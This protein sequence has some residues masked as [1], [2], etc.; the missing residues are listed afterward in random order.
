MWY[1]P[2]C[3][4]NTHTLATLTHTHTLTHTYSHETHLHTYICTHTHTYIC[5]H[6]HIHK[7][8]C[9]IINNVAYQGATEIRNKRT[10]LSQVPLLAARLLPPDYYMVLPLGGPNLA[11]LL[12]SPLPQYNPSVDESAHT[13][14][15]QPVQGRCFYD[16]F[17]RY[18]RKS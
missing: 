12:H 1:V 6:T 16:A 2:R 3:S 10:T 8:T 15:T 4:F 5:T 17:V 7:P 11:Q 18:N 9:I 14:Q 13:Q